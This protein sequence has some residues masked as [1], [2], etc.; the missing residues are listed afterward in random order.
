MRATPAAD[1][2]MRAPRC[3]GTFGAPTTSSSGL[4]PDC[5]RRHRVEV[6]HTVHR[7]TPKRRRERYGGTRVDGALL[8]WACYWR[9][10]CGDP[11]AEANSPG[12]GFS[13][14]RACR[15]RGVRLSAPPQP[16]SSRGTRSPGPV[17]SR[18]DTPLPADGGDLRRTSEEIAHHRPGYRW[19]RK[20]W[21]TVEQPVAVPTTTHLLGGRQEGIRSVSQLVRFR[22]GHALG[23][24]G[25]AAGR[26][27]ARP[28]T[29]RNR[30]VAP[31]SL[32]GVWVRVAVA[33][34]QWQPPGRD[35][36]HVTGTTTPRQRRLR[37][38]GSRMPRLPDVPGSTFFFCHSSPRPRTTPRPSGPTARGG[39]ARP[40]V[41]DRR[42]RVGGCPPAGA[43]AGRKPPRTPRAGC[44]G[45]D[46]AWVGGSAGRCTVDP[47][48]ARWCVTAQ[49]PS[50]ASR[51]TRS[52]GFDLGHAS[53]RRWPVDRRTSPRGQQGN[54]CG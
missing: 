37:A 28:S 7:D 6:A 50:Q 35:P 19:P 51:S 43:P 21:S 52:D 53:A 46:R 26:R 48:E 27:V 38:I 3:W 24:P 31:I 12:E 10:G 41:A 22:R 44:D 13:R 15:V 23:P 5:G 14:G 34:A 45:D 20:L 39:P 47:Q 25:R 32:P 9:R 36:T 1:P 49:T 42:G 29:G 33:R 30:A 54:A 11:V 16:S 4:T 40:T 17:R 18:P 2:N 8:G